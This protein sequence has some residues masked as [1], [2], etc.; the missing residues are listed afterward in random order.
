MSAFP[1]QNPPLGEVHQKRN[2]V[3]APLLHLRVLAFVKVINA[4]VD[5]R[6]A[7]HAARQFLAQEEF[8]VFPQ[9]F[10]ALDRVVVGQRKQIHAPAPEQGVHL[11]GIAITFAAELPDKGGRTRSGKVRVDMHIALHDFH[12][13]STALRADD[14]QAKV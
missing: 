4:D 7:G 9:F 2:Q 5:L 10:G 13:K 8:R 1:C 11:F 3:V 14:M 6:A 12:I